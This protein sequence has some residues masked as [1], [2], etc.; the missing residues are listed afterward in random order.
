MLAA[1]KEM[2]RRLDN[3]SNLCAD[4]EIQYDRIRLNGFLFNVTTQGGLVGYS[5]P[6]S[7]SVEI[8]GNTYEWDHRCF[9][10]WAYLVI[11]GSFEEAVKTKSKYL[12]NSKIAVYPD[13]LMLTLNV[14]YVQAKDSGGGIICNFAGTPFELQFDK[15]G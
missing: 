9:N 14:R 8:G 5:N 6:E 7:V 1:L 3:L 12:I 2:D 15:T 11:P 4:L 10:Q 13:Y